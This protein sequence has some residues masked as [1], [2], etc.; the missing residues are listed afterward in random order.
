MLASWWLAW[1]FQDEFISDWDGLDYTAYTIQGLPSALGLG[2][3]LFLGYNHLLWKLAQ[4]WLGT[5]P[6]NAYLILRYGVI[7]LAGPTVVAIYA[8]FKEL[9]ESRLSA[10]FGASILAASPYFIIYSGRAMSEIPGFLMLA[11]AFWLMLRS[12]RSGST[13]GFLL[14]AFFAG[15]SANIREFVVFYL[16]FIP[17]SAW[18]IGRSWRKGLGGTLL[19]ILGAVGGIIFWTIYA[20]EKYWPATIEWYLLSAQER[21]I[22]PI[23]PENLAFLVDF[24]YN[25]SVATTLL[26]PLAIIWLWQ[27][28][29]RRLLHVFGLLGLLANLVLI[30]N[31]DLSVNPRYMLTGLL[32]LAAICG[33]T[34]A[35]MVRFRG[36][37]AAM[38]IVGL[39]VLTKGSYNNMSRELYNQEWAARE[40]RN[41]FSKLGDMPWNSAFIVGSRTP[42]I[43]FYA[44][45][46][47]RPYWKAIPIGSAWPDDKLDEAI[48]DLLIAG[49]LV[50]ID[51]D[52]EIWQAGQR[53][54][55]REAPGLEM[56]KRDYEFE[57]LRESMYRV[58]GK[59]NPPSSMQE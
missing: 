39:I 43:N 28:R 10:I 54:E 7:S 58:L 1:H 55:N 18:I 4:K 5:P 25:C 56:I 29:E 49:R 59:K 17:I 41:Y 50:Y 16:P 51:F 3:S 40:S 6:E 12:L 8:L 37:W 38:V 11:A 52:A 48:D 21:T 31:H 46:G 34:L 27:Y 2:R 9:S 47:A 53:K 32:G 33:W 36:V 15:L 57:Y 20:P 42:L 30:I 44:V 13:Y 35:E 23:G 22:H 24:S 19:A 26:A 14:A 45:I